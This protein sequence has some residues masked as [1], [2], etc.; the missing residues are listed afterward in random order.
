MELDMARSLKFW[1]SRPKYSWTK[2]RAGVNPWQN[3][4]PN[5]IKG[6]MTFPWAILAFDESLAI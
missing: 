6:M 5:I 3:N 2:I 1:V 4:D